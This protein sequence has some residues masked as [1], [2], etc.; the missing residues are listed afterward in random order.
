MTK[1]Q[2]FCLN[3]HW[4]HH[5]ENCRQCNDFDWIMWEDADRT[6]FFIGRCWKMSTCSTMFLGD[7]WQK[8]PTV[9]LFWLTDAEKCR[10]CDDFGSPT[11]KMADGATILDDK[12]SKLPTVQRFLTTMGRKCRQYNDFERLKSKKYDSTTILSVWYQKNTTVQRIWAYPEFWW[13]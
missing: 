5:A 4:W 1:V 11:A 6:T 10:Q 2:W 3:H 8:M 12:R 9:Q 13:S 7:P